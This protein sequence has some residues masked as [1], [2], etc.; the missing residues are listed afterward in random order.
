MAKARVKLLISLSNKIHYCNR[1]SPW[2]LQSKKRGF[3]PRIIFYSFIL[4]FD[5]YS[6]KITKK[7]KK[8]NITVC[9]QL[10]IIHPIF[11]LFLIYVVYLKSNYSVYKH[12]FFHHITAVSFIQNIFVYIHIK[13]KKNNPIKFINRNIRHT[14]SS[15]II[16]F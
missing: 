2:S 13:Q 5:A 1:T 15:A 6:F 16:I 4:T 14:L 12:F 11:V 7:N 9:S 8:C 10:L 3:K